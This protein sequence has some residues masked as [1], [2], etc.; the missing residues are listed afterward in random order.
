MLCVERRQTNRQAAVNVLPG[1]G[2]AARTI[3]VLRMKSPAMTMA[4]PACAISCVWLCQSKATAAARVKVFA[5]ID[6]TGVLI[7]NL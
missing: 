3:P 5:C 4:S 2:A 7:I 6:F 1:G